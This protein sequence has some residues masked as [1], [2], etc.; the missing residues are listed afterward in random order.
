MKP[1]NLLLSP[2]GELKIGDFG[3]A[4]V[5]V[6]GAPGKEYTPQVATRCAT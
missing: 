5:H 1:S 6:G 2:A 4:R 3:L